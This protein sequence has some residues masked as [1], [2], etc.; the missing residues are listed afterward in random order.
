MSVGDR[1]PRFR[2]FRAASLGIYLLITVIFSSLIIFSV[3]RSVLKM[4]PQKSA[5]RQ[6]QP[7]EACLSGARLLFAELEEE[8][9]GMGG[10]ADV[11]RSDQ[12]FLQ[13]RVGWLQRKA[14]LE[15]ECALESRERA[16]K[17][18]SSLER[19]VDLYTTASVQFSGSVGP[20]IEELKRQINSL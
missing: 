8:R 10:L 5:A 13:F 7:E 6:L 15:S 4:T 2:A 16:R 18:F 20:T 19:A 1:D 14:A 11:T 3:F 12:H 9:K 17:A